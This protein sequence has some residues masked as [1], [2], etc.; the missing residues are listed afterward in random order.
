MFAVRWTT[1]T[2]KYNELC[3]RF[4]EQPKTGW[5]KTAQ[6]KKWQNK[7][8]I[9]RKGREYIII[10]KYTDEEI[11]NNNLRGRYVKLFSVVL[12]NLLSQSEKIISYSMMEMLYHTKM[13]NAA[14]V[15]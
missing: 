13:V 15:K 5:A 7:Y 11:A 8:E 14:I 3:R 4:K 9:E 2:M 10:R 6:L 1:S 12:S